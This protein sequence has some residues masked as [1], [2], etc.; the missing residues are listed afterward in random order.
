[1]E[2]RAHATLLI[3]IAIVPGSHGAQFRRPAISLNSP[4]SQG[5]QT[6]WPVKG[7]FLPTSHKE[8]IERPV[9]FANRP[10]SQIVHLY[11]LGTFVY[12]PFAQGIDN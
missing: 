8:H 1:M 10:G 11:V 2:Q 4:S 12:E 6:I 5:E 3:P 7:F 9:S